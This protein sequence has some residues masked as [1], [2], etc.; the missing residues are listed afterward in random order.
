VRGTRHISIDQRRHS[1][2]I[3]HVI[4]VCWA[5]TCIFIVVMIATW[6]TGQKSSE[7]V[8]ADQLQMDDE[9]AQA[10]I[11]WKAQDISKSIV[12]VGPIVPMTA[13]PQ[14]SNTNFDSSYHTTQNPST[15]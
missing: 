5:L 4:N 3:K 2:C 12:T 13:I 10:E 6:Q 14:N 7:S 1:L 11:H 8:R 15:I 9:D